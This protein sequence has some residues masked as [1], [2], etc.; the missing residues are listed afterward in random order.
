MAAGRR[1]AAGPG[2]GTTARG[3]RSPVAIGLGLMLIAFNLRPALSSVGPLLPGIRA[4]TG[5]SGALAGALVTLPVLCL[6]VFGR[7]GSPIAR[8]IGPDAGVLAALLVLAAGLALR[9]LGGLG[10]LF[11]GSVLAAAGIGI[12]GVILPGIVKRDF[13]DQGGLM[14]GLY[15]A[16]LCLGAAAGAGLTVPLE[17]V[18]GTGWEGAMMAWA[19]PAL[20]AALAWLPFVRARP[21]P[22]A[23]GGGALGSLWGDPLAWQVTAFMGLQSSLA[24]IV[25][26]W[27]PAALTER[28]YDTVTAGLLASVSALAQG[29]LALVVP[30]LA[31]RRRDQRPWVL[32]VVGLPV[33]GFCGLL[34]GPLA[35]AWGFALL[36]GLG[37]GGCFGLALTLIV[38]RARDPRTAGD[39]SAMAQGIGYCGA[40]LGPFLVGIAH[41]RSG[42]WGLPAALYVALGL[43]ATGF[44]LL[45]ARDRTVLPQ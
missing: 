4:E 25:F 6:G 15:T 18:L 31:A 38:L 40:A 10:A 45:A 36:L 32:V 14:T 20:V 16:L 3:L 29:V 44:G 39:L 28:G 27:L 1:G 7:L 34:L 37:L 33:V 35:F 30:T 5:L 42:G 9:G 43:A 23:G 22:A 19:A 2:G 26:G 8:R 11:A 24:Y 21:A 41:E 12:V 17:R 13:P